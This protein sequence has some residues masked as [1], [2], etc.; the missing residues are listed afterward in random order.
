[1]TNS[2]QYRA[3][4]S[5][6]R[7]RAVSAALGLAVV[8]M[9]RVVSAQ[10]PAYQEKLLYSFTGAQGFYPYAG[11]VRDSAGNLYG[12]T[13]TGGTGGGGTVFGLRNSHGTWRETVLYSFGSNDAPHAGLVK[14]RRVISTEPPHMVVI[15]SAIT[16]KAAVQFSNWM[17]LARRLYCTLLVEEPTEHIHLQV[18]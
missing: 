16:T 10:V 13:N 3:W 11:L 1:M 7:L 2:E 6:L 17:S 5:G 4:I 18:C 15:L 8:L 12:T 9:P 14:T